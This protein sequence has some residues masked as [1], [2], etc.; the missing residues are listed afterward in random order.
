MPSNIDKLTNTFCNQL[1]NS[2]SILTHNVNA[3]Q[4]ST[5]SSSTSSQEKSLVVKTRHKKTRKRHHHEVSSSEDSDDAPTHKSPKVNFHH[6]CVQSA[7]PAHRNDDKVSLP[8][9]EEMNRNL[10]VLQWESDY[11]NSGNDGTDYGEDDFKDLTQ[12][13]NEE[14]GL[15]EPEQQTLANIL[16]TVDAFLTDWSKQF[17]YTFSPFILLGKVTSKICRGEAHCIVII[18]KWITQYW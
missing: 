8:D 6:S 14:E 18:P 12:E 11:N 3:E 15:G 16:E 9:E 17:S 1:T 7:A 2:I 4:T 13:L 5:G 10:R